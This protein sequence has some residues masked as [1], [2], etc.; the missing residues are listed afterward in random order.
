MNAMIRMWFALMG[1]DLDRVLDYI[2]DPASCADDP[3][4]VP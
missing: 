3:E 1:V 2:N 4:E